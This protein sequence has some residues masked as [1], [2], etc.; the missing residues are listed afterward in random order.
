MSDVYK[1]DD[2]FVVTLIAYIMWQYKI[3]TV[4]PLLTGIKSGCNMHIC[5][6][7]S[8]WKRISKQKLTSTR[9]IM[10]EAMCWTLTSDTRYALNQPG[11][12]NK[13]KVARAK[14]QL[15]QQISSHKYWLL[16]KE[17]QMAKP[18]HISAWALCSWSV[19]L[20]SVAEVVNACAA[21]EGIML[22][23]Y[24]TPGPPHSS[25]PHGKAGQAVG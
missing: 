4:F 12:L 11:D 10:W 21:L 18:F 22:F 15:P 7:I 25:G 1:W 17:V 5:D 8:G 2:K 9:C 24:C 20:V 3:Y 6:S 19:P 16:L 13:N 14:T 23:P